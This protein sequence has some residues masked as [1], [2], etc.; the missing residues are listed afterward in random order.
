MIYYKR[1]SKVAAAQYV[2]F[3]LCSDQPADIMMYQT[4]HSNMASPHHV[5]VDIHPLKSA[6]RE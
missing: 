3:D 2:T 5:Q 4:H 1:H 6:K